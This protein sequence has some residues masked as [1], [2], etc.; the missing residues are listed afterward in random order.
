MDEKNNTI[1]IQFYVIM[2]SLTVKALLYI[3]SSP[4]QKSIICYNH[5]KF[6]KDSLINKENIPISKKIHVFETPCMCIAFP[7]TNDSE[8]EGPYSPD[9]MTTTPP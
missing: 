7:K 1:K 6:R 5:T 2:T 3:E 4:E 8:D 9:L